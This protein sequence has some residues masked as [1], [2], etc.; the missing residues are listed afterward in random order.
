MS[1]R[2]SKSNTCPCCARERDRE[3]EREVPPLLQFKSKFAVM[4]T[5]KE[6]SQL[7]SVATLPARPLILSGRICI[8]QKDQ[9]KKLQATM[10]IVFPRVKKRSCN[11]PMMV[12]S[13]HANIK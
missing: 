8:N 10:V 5:T 7:E 13:S 9:H 12:V 3:R 11:T 6:I 4:V 2:M 1:S